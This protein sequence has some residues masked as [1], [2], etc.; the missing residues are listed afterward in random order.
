[1]PDHADRRIAQ[2]AILRMRADLDAIEAAVLRPTPTPEPDP[3]PDPRPRPEPEPPERPTRSASWD[4]TLA[5]G[6]RLRGV[7][8]AVGMELHQR[9]GPFDLR[10]FWDDFASNLVPSLLIKNGFQG[11]GTIRWKAGSITVGGWTVDL[12]QNGAMPARYAIARTAIRLE[13]WATLGDTPAIPRELRTKA[14]DGI[15]AGEKHW[16]GPY[17][18]CRSLTNPADQGG[19]GIG[20]YRGG[21]RDWFRCPEGRAYRAMEALDSMCRPMWALND[22]G[23][24]WMPG[25][26]GDR[27]WFDA[28]ARNYAAEW[29]ERHDGKGWAHDVSSAAT[30]QAISD[31]C[32]P[33][34]A[35][36]AR[37]SGS[38]AALAEHSR[39]FRHALVD[40]LGAEVKRCYSMDRRVPVD[41]NAGQYNPLY[42]FLDR[43]DAEGFGNRREAHA[44]RVIAECAL[45]DDEMFEVY[46]PAFVQLL[47]LC[48][49]GRGVLD[50]SCGGDAGGWAEIS[51]PKVA[52]PVAMH[53]QQ[54]L[55]H[56]A[57][58]WLA[59]VPTGRGAE[60]VANRIASWW[61]PAPTPYFAHTGG[62]YRSASAAPNSHKSEPKK[63][64]HPDYSMFTHPETVDF[65]AV[66]ARALDEPLTESP[67]DCVPPEARPESWREGGAR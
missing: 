43:K 26:A 55:V 39:F 61:G 5:S 20:P 21:S 49:D 37:V 62:K 19:Y 63:T 36:L 29:Q 23:S 32:M 47:Q 35:H 15:L 42:W 30:E 56:E 67:L 11:T 44:A 53:F 45:Y 7:T 28:S 2:R 54:A 46:V 24:P 18:F 34:I 25:D 10:V 52:C 38:I 57:L 58:N 27:Y 16:F 48:D 33:D 65:D 50:H 66:L 8:S 6:E 13:H 59:A 17:P 3:V 31:E 4:I 41:P 9:I 1:M 12:G 64:A 51:S 60:A 14:L 22:D 40:G